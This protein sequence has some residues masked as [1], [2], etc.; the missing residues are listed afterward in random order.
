MSNKMNVSQVNERNIEAIVAK[1]TESVSWSFGLP[2][3]FR[4]SLNSGIICY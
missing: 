1:A 3:R 4:N 2:K